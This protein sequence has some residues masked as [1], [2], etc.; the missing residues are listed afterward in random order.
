MSFVL[1]PIKTDVIAKENS[2]KQ[3]IV[4]F[5]DLY[6]FEMILVLLNKIIA[7]H[8]Q[9]SLIQ[10]RKLSFEEAFAMFIARSF[11]N[12]YTNLHGLL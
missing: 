12:T 10:I 8:T 4:G 3:S 1:Y 2:S 6:C 9:F 7:V 5:Y 11:L